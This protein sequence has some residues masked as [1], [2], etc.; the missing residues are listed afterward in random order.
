[1]SR[2]RTRDGGFRGAGGFV[3]A[4][5]HAEAAQLLPPGA[6]PFDP[7]VLGASPIVGVHL[8]FDRPVQERLLEAFLGSPFQWSFERGILESGT[9]TGSLAL[10]TSAAD[11]L[12]AA[13]VSAVTRLA[14]EEVRRYLPAARSATLL[15]SRVV[16]ERRATPVLSPETARLRPGTATAIANL[17]LAGDW[18]DTGLPATL[19]GAALSGHRAARHL[20]R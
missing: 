12:A 1:V 3:L 10:V 5:P 6:V 17:A 19:E 13:E 7:S 18:T 4:V 11:D 9:P 14:L 15:R 8:G 16:K 2:V 20:A